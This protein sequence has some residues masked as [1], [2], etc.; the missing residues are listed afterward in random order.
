[1]VGDNHINDG[2]AI[3]VGIRTLLLQP[4]PHGAPRGLRVI[5]D[6]IDAGS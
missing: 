6:L 5:V 4:V 2:A 3:D 1:M